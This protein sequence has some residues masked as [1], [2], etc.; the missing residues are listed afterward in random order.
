MLPRLA[1]PVAGQKDDI[2]PSRGH[3]PKANQKSAL[4]SICMVD[5][6]L[7][8][9]DVKSTLKGEQDRLKFR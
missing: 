2:T 8:H 3:N 4:A 5:A 9:E 6:K 7:F 1:S